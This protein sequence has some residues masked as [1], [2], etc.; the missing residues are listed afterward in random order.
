MSTIL[1]HIFC[2]TSTFKIWVF[3][4]YV[5]GDQCFLILLS[6]ECMIIITQK[7][8]KKTKDSKLF[9]IGPRICKIPDLKDQTGSSLL[10]EDGILSDVSHDSTNFG[11]YIINTLFYL[12][13]NTTNLFY[14]PCPLE[15]PSPRL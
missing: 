9:K 2:Q 1:S 5:L 13:L 11:A 6:S 3:I 12:I 4:N 8:P 7:L 10:S 14:D 15:N